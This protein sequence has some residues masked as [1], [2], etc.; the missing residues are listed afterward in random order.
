MKLYIVHGYT[1]SR[2]AHWFPW[3][4]AQCEQHN[5]LAR[6]L[7]MPNSHAPHF[8]EWLQTLREEI[9]LDRETILVGHSL[10]CISLLQYLNSE[11]NVMPI[12]GAILVSGFHECVTGL[13]ELDEF[14]TSA[15]DFDFLKQ[16]ISHKVVLSARDDEIVPWQYSHRLAEK[17]AADFHLLNRG[18]HFLDREG[19]LTLPIVLE[20]VLNIQSA[21]LGK[22]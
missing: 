8:G 17:L 19:V 9:Q 14:C 3:L 11:K 2:D 5:I 12:A 18:G 7:A 16:K 21:V 6:A 13:S 20:Q 1:A 10:G 15:L 4:A 22:E